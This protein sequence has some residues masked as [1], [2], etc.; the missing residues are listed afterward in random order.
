VEEQKIAAQKAKEE[1]EKAAKA[2]EEEAGSAQK[3]EKEASLLAA[4]K[5]QQKEARLDLER[6]EAAA[7]AERPLSPKPP[8]RNYDG[9]LSALTKKASSAEIRKAA[10]QDKKKG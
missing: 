10:E 2:E 9:L 6:R 4:A 1:E 5:K 7:S 3:E 8:N